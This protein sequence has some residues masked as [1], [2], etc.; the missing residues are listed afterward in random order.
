VKSGRSVSIIVL[1]NHT[2]VKVLWIIL[3]H[4]YRKKVA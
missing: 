3:T 2:I 4:I 1:V